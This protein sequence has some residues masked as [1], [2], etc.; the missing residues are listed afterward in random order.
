[1]STTEAF[2]S[3]L[4]RDLRVFMRRRSQWLNPLVFFVIVVSLFPLG[5]GPEIDTLRAI[6]PGV[7]WV[8]AL[9]AVLLSLESLFGSDHLDGTL[10][11]LA[12]SRHPLSVLVLAKVLA[13]WLMTG[14][15]LIIVSPLLGLFM[16]LPAGSM[17]VMVLSLLLGT[18][19]LSLIGAIGAALT[20][21]LRNGGVLLSLLILPLFVP[22]LIF[23]AGTIR[24]HMNG[25][26]V[27]AQLSLLAGIAMF[28]LALAPLAIGAAIRIGVAND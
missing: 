6:G 16:Y 28:S 26:P 3:V 7:I 13:H 17:W 18:F 9:L 5:V 19:A 1:M 8:S 21:G 2:L 11:Q 25:L 22:V 14:I 24:G 20:V 27:E 23:G 15:P 10:E 12:M 4:K